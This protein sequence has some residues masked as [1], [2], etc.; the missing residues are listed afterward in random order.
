MSSTLKSVETVW[1]EC[2]PGPDR[3][4]K[5]RASVLLQVLEALPGG[6]KAKA[7]C[8]HATSVPTSVPPG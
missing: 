4:E 8:N 5:P 1:D 7:G 3:G 6:E 2:L